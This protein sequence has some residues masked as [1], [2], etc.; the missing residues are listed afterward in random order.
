M[1]IFSKQ[2]QQQQ[3]MQQPVL[4]KKKIGKTSNLGYSLYISLGCPYQYEHRVVKA[5][6]FYKRNQRF[7]FFCE[8]SN[9]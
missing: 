6:Q 8:I 2:Q 3:K 5:F 9:F 1:E 7:R 4:K